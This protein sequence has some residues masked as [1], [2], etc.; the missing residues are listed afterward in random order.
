VNCSSG[1]GGGGGGGSSSSSSSNNNKNKLQV[2]E[3]YLLH[4]SYI[5]NLHYQSEDHDHSDTQ[6]SPF[7]IASF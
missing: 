3:T 2:L 5:N 4:S 1:G 6:Q 7:N